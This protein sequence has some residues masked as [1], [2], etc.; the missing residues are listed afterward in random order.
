MISMQLATTG[1]PNMH[2]GL[3]FSVTSLWVTVFAVQMSW[4][5]DYELIDEPTT[6]DPILLQF[7]VRQE[8]I[9]RSRGISESNL[10]SQLQS[11]F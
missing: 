6:G 9:G 2:V 1:L 4:H 7:S 3:K 11:L 8:S 10:C 5:T